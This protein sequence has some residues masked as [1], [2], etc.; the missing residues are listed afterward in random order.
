MVERAFDLLDVR[1]A[2]VG[3]GLLRCGRPV[4]L[5]VG[6]DNFLSGVLQL[7]DELKEA[8]KKPII[9]GLYIEIG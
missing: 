9:D 7:R 3:V 4:A 2:P 8:V 1:Y 5:G 6:V